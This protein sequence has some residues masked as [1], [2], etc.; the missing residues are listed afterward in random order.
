MGLS[1][2]KK[3]GGSRGR[4]GRS[5]R[6][7]SRTPAES[8]S[9]ETLGVSSRGVDSR[10]EVV[11]EVERIISEVLEEL[12]DRLG[13]RGLFDADD[14]RDF[15]EGFV[16][17]T[18]DEGKRISK[19]SIVRRFEFYKDNVYKYLAM[20]ALRDRSLSG[21]LA[22]FIIHRAPEIAGKAAP[23][24]Y[25]IVKSNTFALDTL[26]QLWNIYGR[27]TPLEC[28]ICNFK[29][30]RPDLT[31]MVCGSAPDEEDVKKVNSFLE[32]LKYTIKGWHR[33]L[34]E[35]VIRAGY[36]YYDYNDREIKPPSM[37]KPG[38]VGAIITLNLREKMALREYLSKL[39]ESTTS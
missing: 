7:T 29:A 17:S 31:C 28:P 33:S 19:D 15:V 1:L 32:E 12:I 26:R 35:E 37:M 4:S 25:S 23:L 27:P 5:S 13:V 36:V 18:V 34:V 6:E 22:E 10:K 11:D 30:L 20:K 38:G 21:E 9:V 39:T 3:S 8:K 14:L 16:R 24:L 2:Q